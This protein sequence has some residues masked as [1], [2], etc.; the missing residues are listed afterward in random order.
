VREKR[1]GMEAALG[2]VGGVNG[3]Q[4]GRSARKATQPARRARCV[5]CAR[6]RFAEDDPV[7][8]ARR[9]LAEQFQKENDQHENFDGYKLRDLLLNKWGRSYDI[10]LKGT[11]WMNGQT[12]V[13]VNIMWKYQ[14]QQSFHLSQEDYL[15]H[16]EAITHYLKK[17]NAVNHFIEYVNSTRE[18]PRVAKAVAVPIDISPEMARQLEGDL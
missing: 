3:A 18:K 6:E 13:T 12:L 4:S 14:E 15:C 7:E 16:L 11:P 10:Q 17:W 8:M 1:G 5:T 9:A 2:F